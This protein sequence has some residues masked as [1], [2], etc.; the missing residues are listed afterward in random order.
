MTAA[1]AWT[2][3]GLLI[4]RRAGGRDVLARAPA[5]RPGARMA[6]A[7]GE[8]ALAAPRPDRLPA[9]PAPGHETMHVQ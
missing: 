9:S 7:S 3:R 2:G 5:S 1:H 8:D 6:A 4:A